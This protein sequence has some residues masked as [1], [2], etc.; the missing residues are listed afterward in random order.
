M[1][2]AASRLATWPARFAWCGFTARITVA[3]MDFPMSSG[4]IVPI[5]WLTHIVD[6]LPLP[7]VRL[8]GIRGG[9]S[10]PRG[11]IVWLPRAQRP[12]RTPNRYRTRLRPFPPKKPVPRARL[13]R[14]RR[15]R[16]GKP[17][18]GRPPSPGNRRRA[19][20]RSPR[21]RARRRPSPRRRSRT[22][23]TR[24]TSS[25]TTRPI[26]RMRR[27]T[28][29]ASTTWMTSTASTANRTNPTK[30]TRTTI[31]RMTTTMTR[32]RT[33][34]PTSPTSASRKAPSSSA[35]TMTTTRMRSRVAA[36]AAR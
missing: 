14:P 4:I 23:S 18:P 17:L 8:Y 3:D 13:P 16:P 19:P 32:K 34:S 5:R 30:R 26:W 15:P 24:S 2:F 21:P 7:E 25:S 36:A 10:I 11:G 31:T 20:R 28:V 35:M 22:T 9:V 1:A 27:T 12:L 33:T 29:S 6:D